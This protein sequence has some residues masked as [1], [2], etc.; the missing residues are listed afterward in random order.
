M[1]KFAAAKLHCNKIQ[2]MV[3]S[4]LKTFQVLQKSRKVNPFMIFRPILGGGT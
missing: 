1:V 4:T 3:S 2:E